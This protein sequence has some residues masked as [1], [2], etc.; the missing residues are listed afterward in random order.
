MRYVMLLALAVL[1]AG[2]GRSEAD[3]WLW[4]NRYYYGF[5]EQALREARVRD[6]YECS[7]DSWSNSL[8]KLCMRARGWQP[9]KL[10]S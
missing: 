5:A 6:H 2:C 7:R 3:W 1:L 8:Y 9:A 10:K 4:S